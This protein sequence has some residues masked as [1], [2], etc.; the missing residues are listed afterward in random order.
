MQ[1]SRSLVSHN[2]DR[3]RQPYLTRIENGETQLDDG[4]GFSN[5]L[6]NAYCVGMH[7]CSMLWIAFW[8]K[9]DVKFR[10]RWVCRPRT[11]WALV[12]CLFA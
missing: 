1:A 8:L 3:S 10:S 4:D 2:Q 9:P 6:H 7:R 5:E 11:K 12:I